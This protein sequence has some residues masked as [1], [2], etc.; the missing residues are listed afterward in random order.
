MFNAIKEQNEKLYE[1]VVFQIKEKIAKGELQEGDKLPPER[2]LTKMLNVSRSSV[3]EAMKT[4][5][6]IGLVNIKHG[7]GI[8]IA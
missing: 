6:V 2:E 7:Q 8:F 4:L 1:K 5:E 3:R